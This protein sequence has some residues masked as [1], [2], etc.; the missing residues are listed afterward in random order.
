MTDLPRMYT[1]IADWWHLLSAPEDYAEEADFYRRTLAG[2][3]ARPPRR[4]LELGSGGGNNASHLKG[5]WRMTLVDRSRA[6]LAA[7]GRLNPECEHVEGDM[8]SARLGRTFDAVFVHDAISYMTT[9]ADLRSALAT[10]WVHCAPGGAALFAPDATRE[11]FRPATGWGGHDSRGADR[12]GMRYLEWTTD[13]DPAATSYTTEFAYLLRQADG[14]VHC[15]SDRHLCGL[16]ARA[17]WLRW[18]QAVGFAAEA[19][20]W[21]HSEAGAMTAFLGR[22]ST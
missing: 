21:V 1:E 22:R 18:L 9:A 4:V 3:C 2:A 13:P 19:V 20:D 15:L 11:S 14:S 12:R 5:H 7:S 6:M 10:A 16:F 17:E 8:R